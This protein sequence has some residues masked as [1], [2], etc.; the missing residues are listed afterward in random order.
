MPS[1][2]FFIIQPTVLQ[3]DEQNDYDAYVFGGVSLP[4][5][6]SRAHLLASAGGYD[7][8]HV[9]WEDSAQVAAARELPSFVA[10]SYLGMMLRALTPGVLSVAI[11]DRIKAVLPVWYVVG[12]TVERGT[13]ASWV[14]AGTPVV[15]RVGKN[16]KFF[17]VEVD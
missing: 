1:N 14:A 2:L 4:K 6:D 7:F 10:G 13:I 3:D 9:L 16:H 12:E 15:A 17:G 8:I 11:A 5:A